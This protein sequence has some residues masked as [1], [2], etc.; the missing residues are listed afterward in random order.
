MKKMKE[1]ISS[2]VDSDRI[3]T[4]DAC[5]E[6]SNKLEENVKV[7]TDYLDSFTR[8]M[9]HMLARCIDQ[10]FSRNTVLHDLDN[11][12]IDLNDMLF[13]LHSCKNA[14]N[15][16]CGHG[17]DQYISK[18]QAHLI[19]GSRSDH[20][21]CII[22]GPDGSGKSTIL[23]RGILRARE[24]FGADAII[25]PVFVGLTTKSLLAEDIFRSLCCQINLI[26]NQEI[27]IG[28]YSMK[29][30]SSYFLGL[31]NRVS[32]NARHLL[33]FIDGI[34]RMQLS[35]ITDDDTSAIDWLC[36]RLPPKFHILVT[37]S[38]TENSPIVKRIESKLLHTDVI[39][40]VSSLLQEDC[41]ILLDKTLISTR[42]T[43]TDAQRSS[44]LGTFTK[45][46]NLFVV[47]VNSIKVSEWM[48]TYIPKIPENRDTVLPTS[49]EQFI[50]DKLDELEAA[51]GYVTARALCMYL[52]LARF[53]LT[54]VELCDAL[55][56]NN[57]VL[58][59]VYA[60]VQPLVF[61]LPSRLWS[62]A[63]RVLGK[64]MFSVQLGVSRCRSGLW[65]VQF[66]CL[67]AHKLDLH[68]CE[69]N[70]HY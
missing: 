34:E 44:I 21:L 10:G 6:F 69:F 7:H 45:E 43:L 58:L 27:D 16:A 39:I 36:A 5:M 12:H 41:E 64:E 26:L 8:E 1:T 65:T 4:L 38:S 50:E 51:V 29:Q 31:M 46:R 49:L 66:S 9:T 68:H 42:R 14:F 23:A 56:A 61:R 3:L 32:K 33:I 57:D 60:N 37:C 15:G 35:P 62:L 2:K 22:K 30:L 70:S 25:I 24:L 63:R 17:F 28:T 11:R 54:E 52:A 13:H 47:T 19:N 40:Y 18:V 20:Q 48:S 67:A 55:S 53:G 59:S